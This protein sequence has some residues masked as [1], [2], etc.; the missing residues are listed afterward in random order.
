MRHALHEVARDAEQQHERD[1]ILRVVEEH[2]ERREHDGEAEA[3]ERLEAGSD[4]DAANR[5][6]MREKAREG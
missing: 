3:R 6:Q 4:C 2:E 1:G 5:Q